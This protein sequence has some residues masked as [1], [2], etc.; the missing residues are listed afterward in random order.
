MAASAANER[1]L[2]IFDHVVN[3]R[4]ANLK[5]FLSAPITRFCLGY[6]LPTHKMTISSKNFGGHGLLDHT[7]YKVIEKRIRN[8]IFKLRIC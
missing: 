7:G 4:S 2:S 1:M 6:R 8:K 5:E 3:R